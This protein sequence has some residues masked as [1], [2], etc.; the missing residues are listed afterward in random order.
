MVMKAY[1]RASEDSI[2]GARQKVHTSQTKI[3]VVYS[4]IKKQQEDEEAKEAMHPNHLQP[5]SSHPIHIP[6]ELGSPTCLNPVSV[7]TRT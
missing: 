1:L 3:T 5:S 2:T 4:A 7:T 6:I